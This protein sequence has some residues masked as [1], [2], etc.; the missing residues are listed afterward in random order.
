MEKIY[1]YGAGGHAQVIA[2]IAKAVGYKEITFIDD[3]H[4]KF[5]TFTDIQEYNMIPIVLAVGNNEI[6]KKIYQKVKQYGFLVKTLI[7]PS[8]VISSSV[9]IGEGTVVMPHVVINAQATIGKGAII[10]SSSIVEHDNELGDFV[11]ISPRV[12]LAGNVKVSELSHIGIGTCVKEGIDIGK[13]TVIGAGSV[14]VS[15][16]GDHQLAYGNPAKVKRDV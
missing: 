1:I 3:N 4:S 16:L 9:S 7:H 6:R 8:A 2:D 15:S 14:V 13:S 11:H 5:A 12:A 10:N